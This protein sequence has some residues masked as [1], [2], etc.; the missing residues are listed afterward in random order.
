MGR[1]ALRRR[2][3]QAIVSLAVTALAAT[4]A[5][6]A[7]ATPATAAAHGRGGFVQARGTELFLDGRPFR[8]AG[9]N[10]SYLMY[11]ADGL[12]NQTNVTNVLDDA[13]ESRF[14]V[15]RMWAFF[16]VQDPYEPDRASSV[17]RGNGPTWFQGWDAQ[18]G[19]P[20][21]NDGAHGLEQ[22]D[23]AIAEAGRRGLELVLPLTNNWSN[24]GGMDQYV[25]WLETAQAG[26]PEARPQYYHD[27]FYTDPRIRQWFKDWISTLLHRVNTYT[28]VRTI[29]PS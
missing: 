5:G 12:G 7:A 29:P 23:F 15:M 16:D 17:H 26:T 10:N 21:V 11:G 25:R 9:A 4:V 24:F 27:D 2:G 6:P 28:G 19:A 8:F 18:A 14:D 22:L 1:R 3:L 20:V 13:V